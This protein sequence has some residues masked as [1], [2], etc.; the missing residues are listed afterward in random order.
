MNAPMEPPDRDADDDHTDRHP[1]R[2]ARQ[3]QRG[4]DGDRHADQPY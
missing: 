3:P 1:I 2:S 4:D